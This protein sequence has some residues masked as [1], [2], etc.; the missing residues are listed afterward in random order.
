M[1]PFFEEDYSSQRFRPQEHEE[2]TASD[3]GLH[4]SSKPTKPRKVPMGIWEAIQSGATA[5]SIEPDGKIAFGDLTMRTP[6]MNNY[7]AVQSMPVAPHYPKLKLSTT[8]HS[9]QTIPKNSVSQK[10]T[11]S[12]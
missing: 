9:I 12:M 11:S 3:Q 1:Q 8:I 4:S 7:Q 6:P 2:K 10:A 5:F